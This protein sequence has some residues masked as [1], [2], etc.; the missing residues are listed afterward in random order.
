M[1]RFTWGVGA[2]ACAGTK[3]FDTCFCSNH[4]TYFLSLSLV[5]QR[6][7]IFA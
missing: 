4:E 3:S 5:L 2:G 6:K 1:P 7:E